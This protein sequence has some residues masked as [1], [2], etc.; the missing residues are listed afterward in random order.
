MWPHGAAWEAFGVSQW[1]F[2]PGEPPM[3]AETLADHA[4]EAAR[5]PPPSA[6]T[7]SPT[8]ML[9]PLMHG[10]GLFAG[11]I[12]LLHGG[13][14]ATVEG[15]SF[16][17]DRA[18]DAV[19]DTGAVA[20]T[21]VG[22]AFA[23]PLADALE[24]R[25]DSAEA[26][27]KLRVVVS[28]GAVF[29]ASVKRRMLAVQPGLMIVDALGSSES[30]GTAVSVTTVQGESATGGF[31]GVPGRETRLVGPSRACASCSTARRRSRDVLIRT[32]AR[33]PNA[34]F[35]QMYGSTETSGTVVFLPPENHG[36]AGTPRMAGC[37][38]PFPEVALRVVDEDGRDL[39]IGD[40]GELMVRAPL[41]VAGYHARAEATAAAFDGGWYRTSDAGRLDADAGR[42]DADGCLYLLDRVHDIIVL[43]FRR[44]S[45][46]GFIVLD[47]ADEFPAIRRRL[48]RFVADGRLV[49]CEDVQHGFEN[50]PATLD[51][52]FS[53]RNLGKQ[54]LKL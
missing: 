8:L 17:A 46:A 20:M 25:A 10:A 49:Y 34:Q 51:R 2:R 50:A 30:A 9:S 15:T 14:L 28:S 35:V 16:D 24:R 53:G 33:F 6:I 19:R 45:M 43:V 7:R 39:P 42:L 26:L 5:H 36:P 40:V 44:A 54:I 31:K 37:G 52:L 47:W 21:F 27:A 12:V 23:L 41:L 4:A 11:L 1:P 22:D 3:V 32:M 18:I 13:T 48:R 38:E 29:S